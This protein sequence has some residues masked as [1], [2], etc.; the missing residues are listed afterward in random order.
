MVVGSKHQAARTRVKRIIPRAWGFLQTAVKCG[1]S[2]VLCAQILLFTR[3]LKG[4]RGGSAL[5]AFLIG[6]RSSWVSVL[7]FV[8]VCCFGSLFLAV[9]E[10]W[11]SRN[12]TLSCALLCLFSILL[13]SVGICTATNMI[14][15]IT[16]KFVL[17]RQ[18]DV[19]EIFEYFK[20]EFSFVSD[21]YLLLWP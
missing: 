19:M 15:T 18:V 9:W 14:I 16:Y 1:A 3:V 8:C 11:L 4:G 12:G 5:L 20:P 7:H 10:G 21:G 2:I 13:I 6:G 17:W